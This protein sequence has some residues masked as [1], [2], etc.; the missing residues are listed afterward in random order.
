MGGDRSTAPPPSCP[1]CLAA[2]HS[3][4]SFTSS[5]SFTS[6]SL[7]TLL[8]NG[9]S[10]TPLQSIRYALFSSRR[11]VYPS[12]GLQLPMPYSLSTISFLFKFLPTLC[13]FLQPFSPAQK[14]NP[15]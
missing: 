10:S 6:N 12:S 11:G 3:F 9:R 5:I 8:H 15:S 7:R 4:I 2:L 14:L 1:A 13:H